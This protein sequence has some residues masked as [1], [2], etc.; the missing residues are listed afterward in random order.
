LQFFD[1]VEEFFLGYNT[2][3]PLNYSTLSKGEQ[4]K[5]RDAA[6]VFISYEYSIT[7][8]A[9]G[10]VQAGTVKSGNTVLGTVTGTRWGI[11]RK[12]GK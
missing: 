2:F 10:S 1:F 8:A 4:S 3:L 6:L 11:S 5:A 9:D 7:F 12:R